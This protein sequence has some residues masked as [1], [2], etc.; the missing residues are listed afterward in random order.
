MF[1]REGGLERDHIFVSGA[2]KM[3]EKILTH[4]KSEKANK[5]SGVAV[6]EKLPLLHC[7]AVVRHVIGK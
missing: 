4:D 1:G 3:L 2:K 6:E 7:C 5:I